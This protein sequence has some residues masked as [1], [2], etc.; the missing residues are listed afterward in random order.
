MRTVTDSPAGTTRRGFTLI[1]LILALVLFALIGGAIVKT[2]S[3][4]Q[5]AYDAQVQHTDMQQNMRLGSGFLPGELR[6]LD[7]S[8]GDIQAMDSVSIRIRSMRQMGVVCT[9]PVLGGALTGVN[10]LAGVTFAVRDS[11]EAIRYFAQGDSVLIYYEGDATKRSDDVWVAA[12]LTTDP[13]TGAL[14]NCTDGSGKQ[15]RLFTASIFFDPALL[16]APVNAAGTI[17]V[18]S[19]IRAFQSVTYKRL[20]VGSEWYVGFDSAGVATTAQPLVGPLADS[21]GLKFTYYDAANIKLPL[22]Y[23][24]ATRQKVA[25]ISIALALKTAAPVRKNLGTPAPD[26][27]RA[28]LE[29]ALR[30]NRRF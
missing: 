5:R 17:T 10:T 23:D 21:L 22:P 29:V 15:G 19:P 25:R 18:G 24:A 26:T 16:P 1:E 12:S 30:N 20:K 27:T 9:L 2:L 14:T 8:S 3:T 4:G 6:E 28:T 7:A 13:A 11:L